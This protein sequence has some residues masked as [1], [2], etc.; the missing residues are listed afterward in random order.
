MRKPLRRPL[1][2][3]DSPLI[4]VGGNIDRAIKLLNKK[5]SR[6]GVFRTL[7]L[8]QRFPNAADRRRQR[9]KLAKF[10]K[11]RRLKKMAA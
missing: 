9:R 6:A 8:R 2:A 11:Q 5:M 4:S 10:K 7:K 3:K 1:C